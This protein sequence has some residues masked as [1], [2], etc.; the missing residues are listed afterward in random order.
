MKRIIAVTIAL[1]VICTS[2]L[3]AAE[4]ISFIDTINSREILYSVQSIDKVALYNYDRELAQSLVNEIRQEYCSLTFDLYKLKI[5]DTDEITYGIVLSYNDWKNIDEKVNIGKYIDYKEIQTLINA[6]KGMK[7]EYDKD[8]KTNKLTEQYIFT[9]I[10]YNSKSGLI[11]WGGTGGT[12]SSIIGI[13][14]DEENY[15]EIKTE[16]EYNILLNYFESIETIINL[17]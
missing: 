17:L 5:T 3:G 1:F 8:Q 11:F 10:R 15:M 6:F 9:S 14:F 12:F 4:G 7:E 2:A 16:D 13:Q